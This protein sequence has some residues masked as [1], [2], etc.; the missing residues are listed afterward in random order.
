MAGFG[1]SQYYIV[2][3]WAVIIHKVQMLS[4]NL[5]VTDLG[6]YVF[7]H[8]QAYVAFSRVKSLRKIMLVGLIK[9]HFAGMLMQ[10]IRS[11]SAW[12]VCP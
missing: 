6:Q 10:F 3:A 5:A 2:L 12:Q 8:G 4:L 1:L 11:M 9:P 7:A